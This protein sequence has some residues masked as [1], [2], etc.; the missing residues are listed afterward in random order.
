MK[1]SDLLAWFR[2]LEGRSSALGGSPIYATQMWLC[3]AHSALEAV[4]PP[5]HVCRRDW[6]KIESNST[7]L[8]TNNVSINLLISV[9][10]IA[11]KLLRQGRLGSLIDAVR[12]ETEDELL[13]QASELL[14]ANQLVAATVIAGGTLETHLRHLIAKYG[15][16]VTGTGSINA[17]N[18]EIARARNNGLTTNIT[19]ADTSQVTSWGQMRND[20]AHDPGKFNG[21]KEQVDL[22]IR[23]IRSFITRTI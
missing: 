6:E 10:M 21:T 8:L 1:T 19:A 12:A 13:D 9:F 7:N 16:T 18:C 14:G 4:L 15:L 22:M 17:Y 2:E 3:E 11:S 5:S 20:A 23:G